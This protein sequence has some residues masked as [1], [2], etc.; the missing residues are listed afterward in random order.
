MK[1]KSNNNDSSSAQ[2][3]PEFWF[4]YWLTVCNGMEAVEAFITA[5]THEEELTL[6][7]KYPVLIT[8]EFSETMK[9]L[10]NKQANRGQ[11]A[12]LN[13]KAESLK[14]IQ[15]GLADDKMVG[16]LF[17]LAAQLLLDESGGE[18]IINLY[19]AI[20]IYEKLRE[21][22]RSDSQGAADCMTNEGLALTDLAK[23]GEEPKKNL[24]NAIDLY[25]QALRIFD[26]KS[27]D[28]ATCMMDEGLALI[29][30]AELGEEPKKNLVKA[31]DLYEQALRIFDQKSPDAAGCMIDE[32][33]A[34]TDLA[35]LGEE[36][37]KN[38]VKAIGLYEQALRIFDP[39]SPSAARCM[40]NEGIALANLAKLGEEP[41]K[42]LEKAID[43]Y[44]QAL[45]IFDSKS[46]DAAGCMMN[47]GLA[48]AELAKLGEEPK[49]NLVKAID[50]YEKALR[51]FDPKS[52]DA[53]RCMMD[54]GTA[55]TGLA[56]LGAEPKKNLEKAIDL[57]EQALRIFD[58]KSP[59]AARCM[60]NEGIALAELAELG[61]E[62]KKNLE[63]AIDLYKN[64]YEI[65]KDTGSNLHA[66]KV[67]GNLGKLYLTQKRDFTKA[68]GAFK[69]AIEVID[70][71]RGN[72]KLIQ[73]KQAFMEQNMGIFSGAVKACLKLGLYEEALEYVEKG[74]SRALL[75]L[76]YT[77]D[78]KPKNC[79]DELINEYKKAIKRAEELEVELAKESKGRSGGRF[80]SNR[81]IFTKAHYDEEKIKQM[82]EKKAV[83][84]KAIQKYEQQIRDK[85]PDYFIAAKPPEI[86]EIKNIA[87]NI[88]RAVIVPWIGKDN[89]ALFFISREGKFAYKELKEIN[90]K[91]IR[92]WMFGDDGNKGWI[93][94]YE[95]FIKA[96]NKQEESEALLNNWLGQMETIL[97]ELSERVTGPLQEQLSEWKEERIAFVPGG[98]LGLLPLHAM[99]L[100]GGHLIDRYDVIY[101]PSAWILGRSE[102]RSGIKGGN[103]SILG[104]E[105]SS[106]DFAEKEINGIKGLFG[107][108]KVE[109]LKDTN[110]EGLAEKLPKHQIAHFSCHGMY[111]SNEPLQS[112]LQLNPDSFITL[113]EIIGRIDTNELRFAVLSACETGIGYKGFGSEEYL[114]IPAGFMFAGAKAVIGS[115]W[116]VNDVATAM[117]MIK[118]YEG[119]KEGKE[120]SEALRCA[121]VWLK[122]L[123]IEEARKEIEG[124]AE[125]ENGDE[126]TA[127]LRELGGHPFS[128]PYWWAGFQVI[129][130]SDK[131][132][133]RK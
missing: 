76:L 133:L 31:I 107:D 102:K 50:L 112:A 95:Q 16:L 26:P 33:L 86:E 94:A 92:K 91:V 40:A 98:Y 18:R 30:L 45:R 3:P 51:L 118:V 1:K 22:L 73:D 63:E 65:F 43:L 115:L 93:G 89:G 117:L 38:L 8:H 11:R 34:L 60:A 58:S 90:D 53:A 74:R 87:R 6:L 48:L 49:K 116:S 79:S 52:L 131:I 80:D 69:Q 47:E 78:A 5:N 121:Q 54:E 14:E 123:T 130:V 110:K 64:A 85:D 12:L 25:E 81:G 41:K 42:N 35:E 27:P 2:I 99:K 126:L 56:E 124:L 97:A 39:K 82:A 83:L 57:Y 70:T 104:I 4:E 127:K 61:E 132:V 105:N 10:A 20:D 55:L 9:W 23:L 106:L 88:R 101:A 84:L 72:I 59:S 109:S 46:P 75:D 111:E 36:P 17:D 68:L 71:I 128:H 28:A 24:E 103:W 62:P 122:R 129:G 114:G 44:E 120:L 67:L 77:E 100:D 37:K 66:I 21:Q 13:S 19:I 113:G 108:H 96:L 119:L 15:N 125:T 7:E 32:G 29:D